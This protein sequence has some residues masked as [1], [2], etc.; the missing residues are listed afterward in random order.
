FRTL[1]STRRGRIFLHL[2]KPRGAFSRPPD[3]LQGLSL[4][5]GVAGIPSWGAVPSMPRTPVRAGRPTRQLPY[6]GL[7]L[8]CLPRFARSPLPV[9]CGCCLV[10]L[11]LSC[12][13]SSD[14]PCGRCHTADLS[15]AHQ[16][17]AIRGGR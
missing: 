1:T 6:R 10:V 13:N 11:L 14:P 12:W 2:W 15:L 17:P 9:F 3:P 7:R 16:R 4:P 5:I 8:F